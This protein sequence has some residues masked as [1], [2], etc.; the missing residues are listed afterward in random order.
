MGGVLGLLLL[1]N[2]IRFCLPVVD[3][4]FVD[5]RGGSGLLVLLL[6]RRL[7]VFLLQ[8][9]CSGC[10]HRTPASHSSGSYVGLLVVLGRWDWLRLE[11]GIIVISCN[12]NVLVLLEHF[13]FISN[14]S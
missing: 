1:A 8:D 7:G 5:I 14:G 3:A 6:D 2:W 11:N 9:G 13:K 10:S 12:M 4:E